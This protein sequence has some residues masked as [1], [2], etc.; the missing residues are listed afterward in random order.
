MGG[1][2]VLK[3]SLPQGH[4]LTKKKKKMLKFQ[5]SK[6]QKSQTHFVRTIE[7]I[8]QKKFDKFWLR[9]VDIVFSEKLQVHQ[10]TPE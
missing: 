1:V 2:G 10:T 7:K 5:L 4:M 8:I 9:Y 3:F 6:F